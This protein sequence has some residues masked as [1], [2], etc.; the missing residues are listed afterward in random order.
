MDHALTNLILLAQ[1]WQ[2]RDK[3]EELEGGVHTVTDIHV[4]VADLLE[5]VQLDLLVDGEAFYDL[6]QD[7]YDI[8]AVI[9]RV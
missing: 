7:L 3:A 1:Q 5:E 8:G 4:S 9:T 2:S 6:E